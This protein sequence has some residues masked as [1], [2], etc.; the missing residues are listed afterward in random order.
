MHGAGYDGTKVERQA[1]GIHRDATF[2]W[3]GKL[4]LTLV[5]AWDERPK[6]CFV[7]HNPS[8]ADHR[9]DDP[10]VRRWMQFARAWGYGG[11]VAVNLYPVRTPD[12]DEARRWADWESSGPDWYIRDAL[13]DNLDSIV[14][15]ETK[16]AGLV[17]ACWGA[18]AS[19]QDWVEHV[20]EEIM[21]GTEPWPDIHAFGVTQGSHPIHPMARGRNR[22]PDHAVPIVWRTNG[23][24]A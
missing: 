7:G 24:A 2:A 15:P 9:L 17:V 19:D 5:R 13:H 3:N 20:L 1:D 14:V 21:T 8:T 10:T 12:P 6:V 23:I 18:I 4:R 22:V 16:R 11:L